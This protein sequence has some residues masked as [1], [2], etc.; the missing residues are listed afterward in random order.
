MFHLKP[1][2]GCSCKLSEKELLEKEYLL[3]EMLKV[4]ELIEYLSVLQ[5]SFE[6]HL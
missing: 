4:L 3:I 1:F 2:N 6:L 5:K